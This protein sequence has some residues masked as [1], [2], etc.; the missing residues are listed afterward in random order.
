[1][2]G[3]RY[4]VDRGGVSFAHDRG[5]QCGF[6]AREGQVSEGELG[7]G[8]QRGSELE[9]GQRGEGLR[10]VSRQHNDQTVKSTFLHGY[11]TRI[12]NP[13]RV[14]GEGLQIWKESK[15]L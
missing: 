12:R 2:Y 3:Y 6:K 4:D 11:W 14:Q 5:Q 13:I 10:P 8:G 1:M 9:Q 7:Y 15:I